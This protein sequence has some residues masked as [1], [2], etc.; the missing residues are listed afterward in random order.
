MS[1]TCVGQNSLVSDFRGVI[2]LVDVRAT[3]VDKVVMSEAF[4]P[5]DVV[6]CEVLGLGDLRSYW[7]TTARNDLGVIFAK[8]AASGQPLVPISW[9]EMQCPETAMVEK[10]KLAATTEI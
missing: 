5:G 4:R 3:E 2:R 8:S 1:I 9:S 6:R 7:L 10:R